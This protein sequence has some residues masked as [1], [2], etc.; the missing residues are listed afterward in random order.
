M[1]KDIL[2]NAYLTITVQCRFTGENSKQLPYL[3]SLHSGAK[4]YPH[5]NENVRFVS[6][7]P[8]V[9]HTP[10]LKGLRQVNCP[11]I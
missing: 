10:L 11:N 4:K 1:N 2:Q 9:T 3:N 8:E 6:H 5:G 7:V